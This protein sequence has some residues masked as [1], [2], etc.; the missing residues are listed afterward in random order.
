MGR[1]IGLG[2]NCPLGGSEGRRPDKALVGGLVV[3]VHIQ[4]DLRRSVAA[5]AGDGPAEPLQIYTA[6]EAFDH[7]L[8]VQ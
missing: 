4:G 8:L 6:R 1:W 2:A 7:N 5:G 3:H